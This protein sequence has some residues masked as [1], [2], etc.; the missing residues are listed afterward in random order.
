MNA[1]LIFFVSYR[2]IFHMCVYLY[3]C[4]WLCLTNC[5]DFGVDLKWMVR[6]T[7]LSDWDR[8][9]IYCSLFPSQSGSI[10][11]FS[12]CALAPL[13]CLCCCEINTLL[14]S[15]ISFSTTQSCGTVV[16][17]WN[18]PAVAACTVRT[19]DFTLHATWPPLT[20]VLEF[21]LSTLLSLS[22]NVDSFILLE[23]I[24]CWLT[25]LRVTVLGENCINVM[26]CVPFFC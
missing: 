15:S 21:R 13:S 12:V 17:S 6:Q 19:G 11:V 26:K 2:F 16:R 22:I 1:V 23:L 7:R 4:N 25:Y 14:P 3:K 10:P 8:K 18:V 20:P 5:P 24:D 9:D